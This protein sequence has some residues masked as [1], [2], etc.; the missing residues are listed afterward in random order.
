[1]NTISF[2]DIKNSIL[3][4]TKHLYEDIDTSTLSEEELAKLKYQQEIYK[5]LHGLSDVTFYGTN[6]QEEIIKSDKYLTEQE[7]VNEMIKSDVVDVDIHTGLLKQ[8]LVK[9]DIRKNVIEVDIENIKK[10]LSEAT[11]Q[12]KKNLLSMSFNTKTNELNEILDTIEY[13]KQCVENV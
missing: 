2:Q 1:M 5:E 8:E 7:S 13:Y 11:D 6:D 9:L 3:E 10:E 12:T 4:S